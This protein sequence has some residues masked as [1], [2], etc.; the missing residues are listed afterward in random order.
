MLRPVRSAG[1]PFHEAMASCTPVTGFFPGNQQSSYAAELSD[2]QSLAEEVKKV[3]HDPHY[4]EKVAAARAL[5]EED[6][7]WEAI[8]E[9]F[10]EVFTTCLRTDDRSC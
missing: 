6:L 7:P 8:A 5:V 9:R 1:L 4:A 10:I 3:V 2:A